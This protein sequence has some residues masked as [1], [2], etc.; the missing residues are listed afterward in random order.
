MKE[1]TM[2]HFL[3]P[4]H[5]DS[6]F[7]SL[8]KLDVKICGF[9]NNSVAINLHIQQETLYFSR[10]TELTKQKIYYTYLRVYITIV[11]EIIHS[12]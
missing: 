3:D 11:N 12:I 4:K 6:G 10:F 2:K 1:Y 8:R 5:I 9:V 7:S